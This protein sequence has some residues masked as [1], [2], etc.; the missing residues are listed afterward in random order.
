ME[1][2]Q[3]SLGVEKSPNYIM[4][5]CQKGADL[6]SVTDQLTAISQGNF[7]VICVSQDEDFQRVLLIFEVLLLV[8]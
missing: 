1:Q 4:L 6:S 3:E 7:Q 5:K 2:L 8:L